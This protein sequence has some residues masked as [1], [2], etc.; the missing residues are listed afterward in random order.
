MKYGARSVQIGKI[1]AITLVCVN[2]HTSRSLL[3]DEGRAKALVLGM[4]SP[5]PRPLSYSEQGIY[6]RNPVRAPYAS[7]ASPYSESREHSLLCPLTTGGRIGSPPE[8]F[9]TP[10]RNPSRLE[11]GNAHSPRVSEHPTDSLS[12]HIQ[13]S[14]SPARQLSDRND[15]V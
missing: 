7:A 3:N 12:L 4:L 15:F 11:Q 14:A 9:L 10:R 1:F 6:T 13:T 2:C 5:P 8:D